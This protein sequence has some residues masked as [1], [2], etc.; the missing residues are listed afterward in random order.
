VHP[1]ICELRTGPDQRGTLTHN[2]EGRACRAR[3]IWMDDQTFFGGPDKQVPPKV[4]SDKRGP[5][6]ARESKPA[7]KRYASD[8]SRRGVLVTPDQAEWTSQREATDPTSRFLRESEGHACRA[9]L[10]VT[11]HPWLRDGPDKRGPPKA[12]ES[13]PAIER[14]ASDLSRRGMLVMPAELGWIIQCNTT[15]ATSASLR[16][17]DLT[18]RSLHGSSWRRLGC[19]IT[20]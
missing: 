16:E 2:L 14:Y 10:I 6:M 9:R 4:G 13:K 12:R 17:T 5:P 11:S 1:S 8:L 20:L 18:S 3:E 7:I 19:S 15:D